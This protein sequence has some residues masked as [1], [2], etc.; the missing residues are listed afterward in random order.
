VVA[1]EYG[2]ATVTTDNV[3][4]DESSHDAGLTRRSAD[5]P[6]FDI[7]PVALRARLRFPGR[8]LS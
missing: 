7:E 2:Q 4:W 8:V 5:P 1:D 3:G 6:L